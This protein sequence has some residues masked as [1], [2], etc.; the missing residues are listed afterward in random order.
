MLILHVLIVFLLVAILFFVNKNKQT[1][2]SALEDVRDEVMQRHAAENREMRD[3]LSHKMDRLTDNNL[4]VSEIN[5]ESQRRAMSDLSKQLNEGMHDFLKHTTNGMDA[6]RN[7]V[8]HK[9]TGMMVSNE[10]KL[11]EMRTVVNEKLEK[12]LEHRLQKSFE[13]VVTQL[14]SVNKGL[15]E[16]R[17]VAQSV[18]SLNRILTGTKSRGILGEVQLGQIIEDMLPSHLYEREHAVK[19]GSRDRVEYAVKLP[20]SEIGGVV[21]LPI[22]SKFPLEPYER[23]MDAYDAGDALDVD[24]ARKQLFMR[25]KSFAKDIQT[26]YVS[27]PETTHFAVMFLPTEGLYAEVVR[28]AAFFES[29]RQ[30]SIIV[31]GPTTFSAMLNSLQ[32]GFKTLQIQKGAADIERTLGAVK[33]EFV[34]FETVLYKAQ[35]KITQAGT[36]I[37]TLI[38]TRTR[39]I[40]RS[41]REVQVYDGDE[42][43]LGLA[44]ADEVKDDEL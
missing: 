3:Q 17:T 4:Q 20:G 22:D 31:A 44:G 12:T 21:Y 25:I 7:N 29:L 10:K 24:A 9:L 1:V 26:K 32:L 28:D 27:P 34:N 33:K 8:D 5:R 15:G 30:A 35:Q 43:I 6:I 14:E 18:G 13:T 19:N 40:N 38:G 39:A 42:N 37:E 11:D 16:M 36:D 23:L 2:T 41:L